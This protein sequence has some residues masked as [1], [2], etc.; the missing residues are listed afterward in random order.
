MLTEE[1][2][3][4]LQR[5]RVRAVCLFRRNVPDAAS[6]RRLVAD[7]K[8]ALGD[9]ILIGIDQEGGAVMRTRFLP[10]ARRRWRWPPSA[11]RRWRAG[12]AAR[13]RAG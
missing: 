4:R 2:A 6:T 7:L 13:W 12:S 11:T 3:A 8:C 10:Q 5:M 1:E 9:D